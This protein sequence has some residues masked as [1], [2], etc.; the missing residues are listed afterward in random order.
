MEEQK[1]EKDGNIR[2]CNLSYIE[3]TREH[4]ALMRVE[5]CKQLDGGSNLEE[6]ARKT[7]I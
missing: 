7:K 4:R 3:L 1:Y 5:Y 6:R 2:L